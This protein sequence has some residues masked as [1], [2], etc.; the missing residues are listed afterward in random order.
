MS[1]VVSAIEGNIPVEDVGDPIGADLQLIEFK[2]PP[3]R[4]LTDNDR[5][6]LL[7]NSVSRIWDAAKELSDGDMPIADS[8]QTGTIAPTEMW[9]LLLVRMVTRVTNPPADWMED[10][11]LDENNHSDNGELDF[12]DRQD[13]LR[14]MLCEYILIDFSPRCGHTP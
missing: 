5:I 1:G 9:M 7:R 2:L 3:P 6:H 10:S 13:R 14:R 8:S 11:D 4:E 12:Y